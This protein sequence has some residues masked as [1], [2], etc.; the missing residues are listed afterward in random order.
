V[1]T[2]P[3]EARSD[4][5]LT[6]LS[7]IAHAKEPAVDGI[8]KALS[9]ALGDAPEAVADPIVEFIAQGI[10]KNR[11]AAELWRNAAELWRNLV[12]V[13]LSFYK[14]WLSE[15]IRDE[16]RTQGRAQGRA[17]DILRILGR[18]GL[19]VSDADRERIASCNDL[20]TLGRWFDRAITAPSTEEIFEEISSDEQP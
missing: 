10:G 2:D 11:R 17:E 13:D 14:S 1:I 18:R 9:A 4:L 6:T 16:G 7:A 5:A 8:L 15:E 12:A 20:D 19:D 3:D